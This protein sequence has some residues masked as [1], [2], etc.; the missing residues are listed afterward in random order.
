MLI[1]ALMA[2]SGC[3]SYT[4]VQPALQTSSS[5][6]AQEKTAQPTLTQIP[7]LTETPLPTE[8]A[9][10]GTSASQI[11]DPQEVIQ[12]FNNLSASF[13]D[14]IKT[15]G[16]IR[17]VSTNVTFNNQTEEYQ[18]WG[19]FEEWSRFDDD[20][21]LIEA[22]NWNSTPEGVVEQESFL[23]DETFHNVTYGTSGHGISKDPIDFTGGFANRLKSGE[24]ITQE[25]VTYNGQDTWN[26][27]YEAQDGVMRFVGVI[28]FD[29]NS[30]FI[31]GKET[32]F[33]QSDGSLKLGSGTTINIFEVDAEPP[34][35][36]FKQIRDK[37]PK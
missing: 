25:L 1:I 24:N 5:E 33:V 18:D 6:L 10:T 29:K 32:Y 20:R 9:V 28:Y 11:T 22:Y 7:A 35:D 36:K 37:G 2:L 4:D 17:Q 30:G 19:V 23:K 14:S 31:L 12:N 15:S 8:V 16:W 34:L 27:S 3:T 26:F 13:N 21:R